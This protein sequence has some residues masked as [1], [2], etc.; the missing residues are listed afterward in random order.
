M[1]LFQFSKDTRSQPHK[2]AVVYA[3]VIS[4]Y[5][6]LGLYFLASNGIVLDFLHSHFT[7]SGDGEEIVNF[8]DPV[9][10]G[11]NFA[12]YI[13]DMNMSMEELVVRTPSPN[14]WLKLQRKNDKLHSVGSVIQQNVL[15]QVQGNVRLVA[16]VRKNVQWNVI[17]GK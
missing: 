3:S 11:V 17:A 10:D 9:E 4:C 12:G 15:W 13:V 6:L 16:E 2:F 5:V 7:V 14:L 1:L 8:L